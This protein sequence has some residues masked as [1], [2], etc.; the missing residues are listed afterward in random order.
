MALIIANGHTITLKD[1]AGDGAINSSST[2][3]V[4]TNGGMIEIQS[5][6]YTS[7]NVAFWAG[8]K[9]ATGSIKVIDGTI[10]GQEGAICTGGEGSTVTIEGG[11]FIGVDNAVIGNNGSVGFE[12]AT[13]NISGGEFVGHIQ[14]AGYTGCGVY[15][16][17]NCELNITGGKFTIDGVGICARA[18]QVNIDGGEF[19]S[20]VDTAGW[21]GDKK[22]QI[23]A[24]GVYFDGAAKYP[25]LNADAALNITNG[26]YTNMTNSGIAAVKVTQPDNGIEIQVNAGDW[27]VE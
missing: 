18:G 14:T 15:L 22:T 9:N 1:S 10:S 16:P 20:T 19:I 24:N 21:V 13:I 7:G 5:G 2:I 12:G 3:G 26:T 4:A 25:G 8:G 27:S 11:T 17:N 6:S 23:S